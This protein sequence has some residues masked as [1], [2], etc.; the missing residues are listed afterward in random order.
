MDKYKDKRPGKRVL[1]PRRTSANA[2]CVSRTGTLKRAFSEKKAKVRADD[3]NM[4]AYPCDRCPAVNG[5]KPWHL[6]KQISPP[7]GTQ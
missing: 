6:T 3:L 7:K 2:Q 5:F 4:R 1:P